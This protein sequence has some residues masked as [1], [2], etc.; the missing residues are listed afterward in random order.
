MLGGLFGGQ[1]DDDDRWRGRARDFVRR[2]E[3]GRPDEGYTDEE[4][5]DNYRSVAG[6]LSPQQYEEATAETCGR[7][8]RQERREFTRPMKERSGGRLDVASDDPRDL[9]RTTACFLQ[10]ESNGGGLAPLFG[11]GDGDEGGRGA[12]SSARPGTAAGAGAWAS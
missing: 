10:E 4:A 9:A 3:T 8:S 7:M 1:D 2:Y 6:R 12:T 5:A 11:F